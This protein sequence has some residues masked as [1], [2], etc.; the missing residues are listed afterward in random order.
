MIQQY[1]YSKGLTGIIAMTRPSD[2]PQDVWDNLSHELKQV[3]SK[4]YNRS[5][6]N[7][8][9]EEIN[10]QIKKASD[11]NRKINSKGNQ[12]RSLTIEY[13]KN[14]SINNDQDMVQSQVQMVMSAQTI[15]NSILLNQEELTTLLET[16]TDR[17][18]YYKEIDNVS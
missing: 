13:I 9:V 7:P 11:I 18:N 3:F 16:V 6:I 8:V 2:I 10:T 5:F 14:R 4:D 17:V 1:L 15:L 12:L